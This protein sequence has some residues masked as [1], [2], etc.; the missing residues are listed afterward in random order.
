MKI[1]Y[2]VKRNFVTA[3]AFTGVAALKNQ[4]IQH[5]AVVII[6]EDQYFG[7]L[8]PYDI[9]K[10]PHLLAIDCLSAKSEISCNDDINS[11]LATMKYEK[12]EVLPAFENKK[13]L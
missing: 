1:E 8:T 10:K 12:T 6:E 9:L 13:L 7:V 5:S 3:G 2:F 11:V 4:L